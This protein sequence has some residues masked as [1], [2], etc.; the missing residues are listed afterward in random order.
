M[1]WLVVGSCV[2]VGGWSFVAMCFVIYLA[3]RVALIARS[4]L[5][6]HCSWQHLNCCQSVCSVSVLVTRSLVIVDERWY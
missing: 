3:Y 2:V 4:M 6:S 5:S 1:L